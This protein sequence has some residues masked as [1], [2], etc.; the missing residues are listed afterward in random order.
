[1]FE[2]L[3]IDLISLIWQIVAF[4]VLIFMLNRLLFRPIRKTLDERATRIEESMEE[5]ERIKE[6]SLRANQEYEE[7]I[8]EAERQA[9]E[10]VGK[11]REEARL[12]QE[13]IVE[14]ALEEAQQQRQDAEEQVRLERRDLAREARQQ[15]AGLAVLA[16]GRI[17][18]EELDEEAHRQMINEYIETVDRPLEEMAQALSRLSTQQVDTVEVHS[19]VPL[20]A[21]TQ[22]A[23]RDKVRRALG[24]EKPI[25]F[26]IDPKLI[27]GIALQAGDQVI[28][29]SVARRLS[30]LFRELTT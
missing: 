28:D 11:A 18:G 5:A 7:R 12:E 14:E 22:N 1:M 13:R 26:D 4:I 6:Q 3:G 29:L 9:Q 27:G 10:I 20:T 23:I 25:T 21:E 15:V 2:A 24:E 19:A 30:S 8:E 17:I 16:A